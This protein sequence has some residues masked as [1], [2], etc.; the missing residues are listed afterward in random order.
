[1]MRMSVKKF[2]QSA[3]SYVFWL[4]IHGHPNSSIT[5]VAVQTSFVESAMYVNFLDSILKLER[6]GICK[7][8]FFGNM[9]GM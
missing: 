2:L 3:L 9:H 7:T 5:W 4:I 6:L 1:M 8:E